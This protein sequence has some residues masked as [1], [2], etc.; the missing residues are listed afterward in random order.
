MLAESLA[1]RLGAARILHGV[2]LEVRRGDLYGLLGRN[3]AGKTTTLRALLG[4]LPAF[5]GRAEVLGTPSRRLHRLA[6]PIGVALD[7]PGLDDT[8][9]VRA[10]LELARIRGGLHEGRGVDEVLELVRL[11]HRQHNRAGRLSHGQ[12]RRAAVARALL[13]APRLLVLDEP[14]SGLDPEGVEDLLELFQRLAREEGVTVVLSSHHLREVQEVCTRVGVIEEG[15]TVLEG[16]TAE[17]LREAGE[18]LLIECAEV[19]KALEILIAWPEVRDAEPL[20]DGRLRA[21]LDA[22]A[23]LPALLARLVAGGVRVAEF[24][25]EPATLIDLFRRAVARATGGAAPAREDRT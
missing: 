15:R 1:L 21:R 10:N 13:G 20:A 2:D 7:P 8:L 17:L 14:L 4:F 19:R 11:G 24:R 6:E 12:A 5:T 22:G 16:A 3:G 9:S 25:R 23:D 18:G